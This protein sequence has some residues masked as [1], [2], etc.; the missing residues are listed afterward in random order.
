MSLRHALL[1]LLSQGSASGY[2]LLKIFEISLANVWPATQSQ[3]YGELGR[4]A[5]A[6]LIEVVAE[7]PRGRKAYGPTEAGMAELRHWLVEVPPEQLR[8]SDML[9][10]V[11]FLG[12][13]GAEQ[14]RAYLKEQGA[15]ATRSHE[16]LETIRP[17]VADDDHD[18]SVYGRIALEW[19]L[20]FTRM[21]QEWA[22][23]AA[24]EIEAHTSRTPS[25][26]G[27]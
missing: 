11:F 25:G 22:E 18:L 27:V 24:R 2:D 17:I 26:T 12:A 13:V 10:R 14:A 23:W 19:G 5:D 16:H 4:L 15:V 21:Q 20:R 3:L 7:G 8:R 1:G 9:L 6:G